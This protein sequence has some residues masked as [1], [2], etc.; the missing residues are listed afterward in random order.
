MYEEQFE[1]L[2]QK[3][4]YLEQDNR[5]LQAQIMNLEEKLS[6]WLKFHLDR[7]SG[8]II[9]GVVVGSAVFHGLVW[10]FR[11]IF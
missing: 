3:L 4:R 2:E 11:A 5:D 7:T 1:S 8:S 6:H 10:L 9:P